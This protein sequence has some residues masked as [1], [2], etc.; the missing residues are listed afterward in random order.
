VSVPPAELVGLTIVPSR[1]S[2]KVTAVDAG[3]EG[4]VEPNAI[5]TVPRGEEPFFLKVTNPEAT[6]GGKRTEFPRVV[7]E[8][9][10]KAVAALTAQLTAAFDER[11]DDPNLPGDAATVFPETKALEA[12]V[13]ATDPA[14]LVGQEVETFELAAT[15]AGTVV[16]VDTTP[17][18]TVA[19]A[20]IASSVTPGYA[21]IEGSGQVVPAPA[22]VSGSVITFP[23][24]VTAR[25]MLQLDPG[26]IEREIMGKPLAQARDILA[27]YGDA[28]LTV[29]PD[30]VGT[31]P[32]IDSRVEVTAIEADGEP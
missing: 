10:D 8:D 11:L 31:V 4:N 22:E 18:Q 25:Q 30:W 13:F 16:A 12:P 26:M 32:T 1:R 5:Q 14:T 21:L 6:T 27:T 23:V 20:R 17:V 29:W 28:E 15:S 7:Q 3:P 2:V 9:V 24:V 19:E